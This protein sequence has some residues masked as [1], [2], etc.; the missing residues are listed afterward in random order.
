MDQDDNEGERIK[1]ATRGKLNMAE[2]RKMDPHQQPV[3]MT[4]D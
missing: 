4:A 1:M 2:G 3:G